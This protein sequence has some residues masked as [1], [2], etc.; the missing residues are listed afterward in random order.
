MSEKNVAALVG[1]V[2]V[3]LMAGVI[4]ISI[5][6]KSLMGGLFMLGLF[7]FLGALMAA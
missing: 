5:F 7:L 1:I 6:A 3:G 4:L 2:G